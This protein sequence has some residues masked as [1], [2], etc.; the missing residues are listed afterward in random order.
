MRFS[1]QV[2]MCDPGHYFPL[3]KAAE[4]A[5]FDGLTIPD[6]ICYPQE[7][8][9]KYPYNADGSREFLESVPFVESL[10]AVAAMAAVT[11]RIRFSTFVYK[12]AVRQAAVVAKQVQ[13]IQALSGNRFDFGIGISPWAEDFAVCGVPW[14]KR[15]KRFD[16]QIAILRGLESGEFFG[17]QG[18]MLQMPANKMCPA[19]TAPTPLLIGGHAEPALKRAA[20]LGDGWMCAGADMEELQRY[21][22]RIAD[23]RKEYG[24]QD[25]P[26]RIF[27]TGQNAF[28]EAGIEE[29]EQIGVTD[30]VIG[31]RNLYAMEADKTLEEKIGMLQW[32]ASTFIKH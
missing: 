21:L 24:T 30:V 22:N 11:E 13:G 10:I 25:K 14:E 31:F 12:L 29:L 26:F 16:E 5:G 7:A 18:E 32:Y 8:S 28:T 1:L 19:P 23:L 3:A 20:K 6:S 27:T 9:S 4:E 15:G 17:H 2:G